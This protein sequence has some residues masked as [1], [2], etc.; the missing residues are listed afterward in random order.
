[1]LEATLGM[2]EATELL[3]TLDW[4]GVT[5]D[6]EEAVEELPTEEVENV[7]DVVLDVDSLVSL[8]DE[9]T[10]EV[11]AE[12]ELVFWP[13]A[14]VLNLSSRS[15]LRKWVRFAMRGDGDDGRHIERTR[16]RRKFGQRQRRR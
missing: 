7:D 14:S 8:V 11:E 6:K 1:M 5:D 2:D 9:D 16:V 12:L 13:R 4:E 15:S 10:S 3:A